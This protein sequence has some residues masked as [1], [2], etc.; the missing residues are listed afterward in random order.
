MSHSYSRSERALISQLQNFTGASFS[1]A[2]QLLKSNGWNIEVA[3]DVTFSHG[4]SFQPQVPEVDTQRIETWFAPYQDEE[5]NNKMLVDGISKFCEDLGIDPEDSVIL[6]ISEYMDA[7]HML[8]Y[9]KEEFI[10]G[11]RK[12]GVDTVDG[13]RSKLDDL[14]N[15][16]KDKERFQQVYMFTFKFARP[17]GQKS[18]MLDVAMALWKILLA[19]RFDLLDQWIEFLEKN[20]T[21]AV[22]RDEWSLV[23]EFV[24]KVNGDVESYDED[25]AWP[26]VIDD[27]VEYVKN[28]SKTD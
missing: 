22:T 8:E 27:F 3:A 10:N 5:S 23:L 7:A 13:L 28:L 11:M 17:I 19:D 25:G 24:D 12:M 21:T 14:R 20:R 18:M 1:Q 15:E 6:V 2:A 16:L 4:D 9:T 26:I